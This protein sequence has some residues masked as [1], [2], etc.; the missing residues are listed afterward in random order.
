MIAAR[1]LEGAV[2]AFDLCENEHERHISRAPTFRRRWRLGV[3][4]AARALAAQILEALDYVGVLAVEMFVAREADG[5]RAADRQRDRAARSQF[6]PLDDRRRADVAVRAA[7]PRHRR[8]AARR[9]EPARPNRDAQS[10]RRRGRRMARHS[11]PARP[12]AAS[13]R[14]AGGPARPQDGPCDARAAGA[15]DKA[16]DRLD[17]AGLFCYGKPNEARRS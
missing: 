1:G 14:Q 9:D 7:H 13:L 12:V 8:L 4:A 6:R 15:A 11:R 3:E 10:D 16:A 2:A 17:I 5:A